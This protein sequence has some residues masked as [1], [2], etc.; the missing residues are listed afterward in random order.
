MAKGT[1]KIPASTKKGAPQSLLPQTLVRGSNW[2]KNVGSL[3][4]GSLIKGG[5]VG[6]IPV[7][8]CAPSPPAKKG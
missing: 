6:K 5:D 1:Y 8:P 4:G 3:G 7:P 2:S